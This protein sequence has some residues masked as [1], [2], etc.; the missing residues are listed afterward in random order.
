[1]ITVI[2]SSKS[3]LSGGTVSKLSRAFLQEK[4]TNKSKLLVLMQ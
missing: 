4:L 3:K 1:M 2:L